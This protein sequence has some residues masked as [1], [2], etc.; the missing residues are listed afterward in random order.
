MIFEMETFCIIYYLE[1][2]DLYILFLIYYKRNSSPDK[3]YKF[4]FHF[5][6]FDCIAYD[7]YAR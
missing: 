5:L 6:Y 3:P 2:L 1:I 7:E 4:N